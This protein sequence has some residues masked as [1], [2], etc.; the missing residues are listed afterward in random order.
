MTR[1][2]KPDTAEQQAAKGAPGKRMTSQQAQQV[3][4]APP[5]AISVG[6]V[7]PPKWLTKNRKAVEVWNEIVPNLQRLNLIN[8][9]SSGP[10][11]RYCVYV[12]G[13][14]AA[15]ETVRKDGAWYDA[16]GTN[17]EPLKKMHPAFKAMESYQKFFND[18]EPSFGLRPDAHYKIMRDQAAAYGLGNLPLWGGQQPTDGDKNKPSAG[19][20]PD[21]KPEAGQQDAVGLLKAFD[22][23][24]P[25]RP[26]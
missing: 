3:R 10:F 6:R 8:E 4:A 1:G 11:A 21:S 23:A 22:S 2:R 19:D 5:V 15:A 25:S 16:T 7:I 12:V 20:A 17:G 9:L 14:I 24:P 18:I 26:N 13:W